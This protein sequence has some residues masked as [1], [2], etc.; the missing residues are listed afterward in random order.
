MKLPECG[1]WIGTG[2]YPISKDYYLSA[3]YAHPAW[4]PESYSQT[5]ILDLIERDNQGNL[6]QVWGY[7]RGYAPSMIA[8]W[9]YALDEIGVKIPPPDWEKRSNLRPA[10]TPELAKYADRLGAGSVKFVREAKKRGIYTVF[11]YGH[12][13]KEWVKQLQETGGEHYLGYDFGEHFS[14]GI[15]EG[16]LGKLKAEEIN[17]KVLADDLLGRVRQL[18]ERRKEEGW[19]LIMATS[20]NFGIDYEI[21][22]GT[23]VPLAEDFAFEHLNMAS[24]I[25]R[26]LYRQ[27][28]LPIW[29]SHLAHEHYSWIPNKSDYKFYLLKAAMLQKYMAGC[30]ILINESGNWFVEASL[31]ED[32]PKFDFPEVP[33]TKEQVSWG[34]NLEPQFGPYIE[35][36]RKHYDKIGYDGEIPRRYRKEISDFYDFV[37]ANGTPAGQPESTIAV[38]KGNYDLCHHRYSPNAAVAG[39]FTLADR[40]PAWYE[41]APERGWEIV[42][43][44]FYPRPPV[45]GE[46]KNSFLSGTP[47]GMVDIVSFAGDNVDAEFLGRQYKALL[48]SGWNTAS[49][50]QY[51]QLVAYV[52]GGGTL[53]IGIPHLSTNITRNYANYSVDELVHHGDFSAL[54]GVKVKGRGERIYWATPVRGSE[55]LGVRF[56]RRFGILQNCLGKIEI[57]D[58]AVESL[59]VDDEAAAPLLL[60]RRLGKGVVYFLNSWGY[61]GALN[62]DFGPGSRVDS[63]GLIGTIYKHI[64]MQARGDVWIS[65]DGVEPGKECKFIAYSYFPESDII[66]LFNIDKDQPHRFTLHRFGKAEPIDLGCGEFKMIHNA[67][68]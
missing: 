5:Q 57:T 44:I 49:L 4:T 54:C 55:E 64:A 6:A 41:G 39:V 68:E 20:S 14:F 24:A 25:S 60:R 22:A 8:E 53:F 51:E 37:K 29:G 58:P 59:I 47:Y 7:A 42:K 35:E 34:P 67:R 3:L 48:F 9:D 30:K 43:E 66:C 61:P 38:I 56:P 32:S 2:V 33:L 46:Y 45:L 11:I 26:G 18:V 15:V 12:A 17:L 16:H 10:D 28:Q 23:D 21:A 19:G 52:E 50:K 65:D 27:Y 1:M 13:R 63:P 31:C 36:A 40:N 62:E